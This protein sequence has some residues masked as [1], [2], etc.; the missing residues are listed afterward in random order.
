[1]TDMA[2]S[3]TFFS[4]VPCADG[5]G[6][7]PRI[8]HD[9]VVDPSELALVRTVLTD[10]IANSKDDDGSHVSELTRVLKAYAMTDLGRSDRL[11]NAAA[12]ILNGIDQEF[13][14][15]IAEELTAVYEA[16]ST[17]PPYPY[18]DPSITGHTGATA[19][20]ALGWTRAEQDHLYDAVLRAR[21]PRR[22]FPDR[23]LEQYVDPGIWPA[24]LSFIDEGPWVVKGRLECHF[25]DWVGDEQVAEDVS[26][27]AGKPAFATLAKRTVCARRL[28]LVLFNLR[29]EG[30]GSPLL[31]KWTIV[32]KHW[33]YP[34]TPQRVRQ[35][36]AVPTH[37][38][39][40]RWQNLCAEIG[41]KLGVAPGD[42]AAERRA[43]AQKSDHWVLRSGLRQVMLHR[44]MILL[45]VVLG[46]RTGATSRLTRGSLNRHRKGRHGL[47][48]PAVLVYEW[49]HQGQDD[50]IWKPIPED[51]A[52]CILAA[53]DFFDRYTEA[54]GLE[55]RGDETPMLPTRALGPVGR[56]QMGGTLGGRRPCPT[57]PKG[58]AALLG[59][60]GRARYVGYRAHR[61][62]E[63]V[64][65]WID[66]NGTGAA[67]LAA[68]GVTQS[69]AWVAEA[70]L[71]H[72]AKNLMKLYGGGSKPADVEEMSY[73]GSRLTWRLLT[74][75]MGPRRAGAPPVA[76]RSARSAS[77]SRSGLDGPSRDPEP[78]GPGTRALLRRR[79]RR[80]RGR[81][82]GRRARVDGDRRRSRKAGDR[83]G[84]RA[85]PVQSRRDPISGSD[86]RRSPCCGP[87]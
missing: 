86:G 82:Q 78:P 83:L 76:P 45:L 33:R 79:G 41:R 7:L 59:Q 19:R 85:P 25:R 87:R 72:D 51:A 39:R 58:T 57:L 65:Q 17:D 22:G 71:G 36:Y 13:G 40:Y 48:Y 54:A 34:D 10:F 24:L 73:W 56:E 75:D 44:L 55:T 81:S 38:V 43:I 1:M 12:E 2:A 66:D 64:R 32:P 84:R 68:H 30:H 28:M 67:W 21:G 26:R 46:T 42:F 14:A 16:R 15:Q 52:E 37:V 80:Q 53:H 20:R 31:E 23:V 9:R 5:V 3:A 47:V 63:R 49:K 69:P 27:G 29:A 18:I 61:V 4:D 77:R 8:V 50:P 74:T 62:R 11:A 6:P 35:L 60:D 70:M